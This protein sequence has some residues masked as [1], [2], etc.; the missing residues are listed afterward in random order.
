MTNRYLTVNTGIPN[1]AYVH[2]PFCRRRC[3]YCDFPVFVVGDRLRGETSGS[4]AQYVEVLCQEITMT[5]N[6]GEPLVTIFFGGGTPSLLSPQQLELI[7][8]ALDRRFGISPGAEISV[9]MD[10]GTFDLRQIQ[11]YKH[12]GVNRVSLGVQAFQD[13][14]LKVCGRSHSVSDILASVDL[15]HQVQIPEFSLDLISGLPHQTL[16]RWQDSLEKAIATSPTHISI[17]D[18][19]IESSTAFGRYYKP[20]DQPLPS[21]ETTVKMYQLAQRI[22]TN[23]GY[24]HYEISNYAQ[25]GHQ[26]RHNLVYWQNRPYYGFGMGAASYVEAKRFTRPR[27][28]K[29]YYQWIQDGGAIDCEPTASEEVLLDT[30]MLGLRL[31]EGLSLAKLAADF[32][33]DRVERIHTI[34]QPYYEKGWV[35]VVEGRLR[36]SD[37]QGFLFSNVVL[38]SLFEQ[39]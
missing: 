35:K 31:A 34:C 11:K 29:E 5:P 37:P 17:Y 12:A 3:F 28:T 18:L 25:P 6:L 38:A 2:I 4:I 33:E 24:E 13:D 30:L 21:D 23:A 14:L 1:S 32:G 9:E 7:L 8:T 26:C 19:T 16:D 15:I 10:P 39:L 27:K 22:L 36:L 20:G